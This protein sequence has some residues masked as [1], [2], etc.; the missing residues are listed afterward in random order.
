MRFA[1][2]GDAI[3]LSKPPDYINVEIFPDFEGDD[4]KTRKTNAKNR[5][6]WKDSS[7]VSDGRIV[8]PISASHRKNVKFKRAKIRGFGGVRVTPSSV[9]LA[10]SFPIEPGFSVTIHK[11]QVQLLHDDTFT[12]S[13]CTL[14]ISF[15]HSF[16]FLYFQGPNNLEGHTFHF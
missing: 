15:P 3:E 14:L 8:I 16:P 1:K 9:L 4:E 10:D 7:L 11:A 13:S 5:Q 12:F 2:P 6:A